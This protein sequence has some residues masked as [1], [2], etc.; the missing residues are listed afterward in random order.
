MSRDALIVGVNSYQFLP[1]L[2]APGK[3]AEAIAHTLES[4]GDFRVTRL[5][6]VVQNKTLQVGLKTP[7]TLTQLETALVQLFKPKGKNIPQTALFYFS[8]HGL[9][10]EAGIQEGYLATSDANPQ[11]NFYGLSLFWLRRLLQESPVRQRIVLLDCCHSGEILNYLE[12]DPGAR[13]GTDRLFMAASR[14]YESAYESLDGKYSVFTQALLD[15]LD[16]RRLAN[17]IV[18]NY[19]LTDWVSNALKGEVQQPLFENSGSEISLTR[20]QGATTILQTQIQSDICP[21]RGLEYFDE[22]HADYFFGREDLTDQLVDQLKSNNFLAVLGASGSGKSS[23]VRAG[24]IHKLRRGQRLSGSD[25]WQIK[26]ITPTDQPIKSLANAFISNAQS[27]IERAEQLKR[28]EVFLQDG[29]TGLSHLVRASLMS[30][31][32]WYS[33]AGSRLVLVIDQFEEVFTLCQ[34]P[35]AERERHRFFNC[36]LTAMQEVG[37]LLSIVVV[38]RADFFSKFSLY[39]G[40]AEKIEQNLV[41]VTPLTYDQIKASILKPAEKVGLTCDPNL[42]YNIMYDIA[43]SPGELPLLQYTL[44][45]LWQRRVVDVEGT[46]PR[47]TLDAYNELGGVRGTLQK[48]AN[49]VFYSLTEEEQQVTKRIFIALTQLGEGTEDTR[50]RILKSDLIS[51]Q[52]PAELIDRV[53][54]KLVAAKLIVTNQVAA[55]SRH[56]ERTDQRMANVSTAL[57]LVQIAQGKVPKQGTADLPPITSLQDRLHTDGVLPSSRKQLLELQVVPTSSGASQE[58]VDIAHEVLIRNWTMLRSWLD[59]NRE[60]LRRQRRIERAAKEWD[61]ADQV[62][63]AEYLLRGNHL[64]DAE[65]FL[66][67]YPKELSTLAQQFITISQED[68]RQ[69]RRELRFLQIAV[70]CTL[71]V[72]LAVTFNQYWTALRNQAEK[73]Y[74][75]QIS[76]SRQ[77]AA[78]AQDILQE[79]EGDPS[80]ALLISRLAAEQGKTYEAEVSLRA[81]LQKLRLQAEL[82][83]HHKAVQQLAFNPTQHLLATASGDGTIRLWSLDTQSEL[84]SLRWQDGETNA[85]SSSEHPSNLEVAFTADGKQLVAIAHHSATI[86]V[87]TV[88]SGQLQFQLTG[89]PQ[90]ITHLA[91]QGN[92]IAAAADKT[93]MV[94]QA[95]TGDLQSQWQYGETVRGLDLTPDG[96]A[97]VVSSGFVTQVQPTQP[98]KTAIKLSHPQAI[99]Q[100]ITSLNGQVI[101]TVSSDRYVRVWHRITGKLVALWQAPNAIQRLRLSPD[102]A[103]VA[104]TDSQRQVMLWQPSTGQ[105]WLAWQPPTKLD[106]SLPL[107]EIAFSQDGQTLVMTQP[108]LVDHTWRQKIQLWDVTQQRAIAQW[109]AHTQPIH[110]VAWSLDNTLVVT[111][112]ADG[113][114]RLWSAT[115][116]G[117]FP[118]LKMAQTPIQWVSFGG[119]RQLPPTNPTLAA[120]GSSSPLAAFDG[121]LTVAT[122]GT[123]QRWQFHPQNTA[124]TNANNP[125][126]LAQASIIASPSHESSPW[127]ILQELGQHLWSMG[128]QVM[129]PA[130][131]DLNTNASHLLVS[132]RN[133]SLHQTPDRSSS[134]TQESQVIPIGLPTS[135]SKSLTSHLPPG[136][137]LV[138]VT[139]SRNGQL[140]ATSNSFGGLELWQILPDQG[141]QSLRRIQLSQLS[142]T[143]PVVRNLMFS[144]D[145]RF[146]LGLTDDHHIR[147]WDSATGQ[148]LQQ[149]QGHEA[150]VDQAQF[151]PDSQMVISTAQDKTVRIWE[152]ESG[153]QISSLRQ[154]SGIGA[155]TFSPDGKR[156]VV[157]TLNGTAS[158]YE[159]STGDLKV[160]LAG[161]RGALLDIG[162]SP[163]GQLL[164][165]ASADGTARVW[166]TA[167]GLEKA[168]L[169][170]AQSDRDLKPLRR[171]FFSPDGQ[172]VATLTNGGELQLWVATWERLMHLAEERSLRPLQPEECLRYLRL[173]PTACPALT[174]QSQARSTH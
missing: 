32:G 154:T 90:A 21:Y 16:P 113:S 10:K 57:R 100:S 87:W 66:T 48:R 80:A 135:V 95:E 170:S 14:E 78:I 47:M 134:S 119:N 35:Q 62:R 149:L 150:T 6:E 131:P 127:Q 38:V 94:W 55:T 125:L 99:Q 139:F 147:V 50:R 172:Y 51:A 141:L 128:T 101:A 25:R 117:E 104:M 103:M 81:S 44:L 19:A 166:D 165:T 161:H 159:R 42:V 45:E 105:S 120:Y 133:E 112:A 144:P 7:V 169:R 157:A 82:R 52:Y 91:V 163:D 60:M 142:K 40:I 69:A 29:G 173:P 129:Q 102:G 92:T 86:K 75:L 122:N 20:C 89:L 151:S 118:T 145:S 46:A 158:I 31:K 140:I 136:A 8:G 65:E 98:G 160:I 4:Y 153:R 79:P 137:R 115:P 121:L 143:L 114:V 33:S 11:Y 138:S 132:S 13:S 174:T 73:E 126:Q 167:T 109:Q 85:P 28:A 43:G 23:L 18:S 155:V 107:S 63:S 83:G 58:T 162:F 30:P 164:V 9:Q 68:S 1:S 74:Q 24:L 61:G 171:A 54:E 124:Q 96:Q 67:Q 17:G 22:V 39:N 49:E 108:T 27:P 64:V 12:A 70:P 77:W 106:D 5:P 146:L 26:L 84:R 111:A 72:A 152:R 116:G 37:D 71:L 88:E 156:I 97:I 34:G 123:F 93:V 130:L 3:D 110:Q 56:Q 168:I 2:G 15:G 36:L 148:L 59:E 53:V 76:T 41:V